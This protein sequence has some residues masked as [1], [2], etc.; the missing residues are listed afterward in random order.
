MK[1]L[2]LEEK[3]DQM[4]VDLAVV[5]TDVVWLKRIF[6]GTVVLAGTVFGVD[7]SGVM[8]A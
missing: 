6:F 7:M 4:L 2:T 5:K 1:R 8:T 3:I